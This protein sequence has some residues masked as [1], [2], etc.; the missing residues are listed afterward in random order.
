MIQMLSVTSFTTA[1][2]G[3]ATFVAGV[4][5]K[6]AIDSF[7]RRK[8]A[9]HKFVL[10]K[11]VQ[12]LEQQLSQFYWPIYLHLQKD[13]LTWERLMERTQDPDTPQSKLSMRIEAGGILP[14]HKEA[15]AVIEANLHL[16]GD[17]VIVDE[18]IR[19]V[20]HAKL[21]EMLREAG[22][23]DDPVNHGHGYP[24]DYFGLAEKLWSSRFNQNMTS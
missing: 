2:W 14:S 20:R 15:L 11:R 12:F 9:A 22:I 1:V 19:Y 4:A 16:A 6:S 18:S 13:N 10:D 23:K 7:L 21:Y 3:G 17:Q 24:R 5:T 8:E